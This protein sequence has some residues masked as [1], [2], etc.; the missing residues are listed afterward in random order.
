M[1]KRTAVHPNSNTFEEILAEAD[2]AKTVGRKS[3]G[4]GLQQTAGSARAHTERRV[5]VGVGRPARE[6]TLEITDR[7]LTRRGSHQR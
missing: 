4:I 5:G 6:S 3:R 1:T 7:L 2:D